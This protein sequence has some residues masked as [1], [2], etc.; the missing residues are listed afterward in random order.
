MS[1][2]TDIPDQVKLKF[3]KDLLQLKPEKVIKVL[4]L[5]QFPFDKSIELCKKFRN[6]EGTA[7]LYTRSGRITAAVQEYI[8]II[9][10]SRRDYIKSKNHLKHENYKILAKLFYSFDETL[11]LLREYSEFDRFEIYYKFL[12]HILDE[13]DYLKHDEYFKKSLAMRLNA[14]QFKQWF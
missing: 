6:R 7:F 2:H 5:Y 11:L 14:K 10:Q 12:Y 13:Y 3:L 4:K 8:E 9:K 1:K